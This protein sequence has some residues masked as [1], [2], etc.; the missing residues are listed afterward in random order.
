MME[1][2]GNQRERCAAERM[3][4]AA[5]ARYRMQRRMADTRHEVMMRYRR[6]AERTAAGPKQW[7]GVKQ[8]IRNETQLR[9]IREGR[10]PQNPIQVLR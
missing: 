8:I 3:K 5:R 6:Q 2:K 9:W 1:T 4:R 10:K 7:S